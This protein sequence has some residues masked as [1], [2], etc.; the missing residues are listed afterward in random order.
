MKLLFEN[1]RLYLKE[2]TQASS[3]GA[4]VKFEKDYTISL[5][6]INLDII[7]GGLFRNHPHHLYQLMNSWQN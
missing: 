4:T 1:W 2:Q 7:T 6:L 3:F 5:A